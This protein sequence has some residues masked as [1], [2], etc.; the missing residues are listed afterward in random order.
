MFDGNPST[1]SRT[2]PTRALAWGRDVWRQ[3][4][5][6]LALSLLGLALTVTLSGYGY[7]VSQY[8]ALRDNSAPRV[9][10]LKLWIEQRFWFASLSKNTTFPRLKVRA[11]AQ[12]GASAIPAA[13]PEFS[14]LG[15][16]AL[17]CLTARPRVI[18][19]FHAAIPLRSPPLKVSL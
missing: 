1:Q 6:P 12:P 8:W 2:F 11:Y 18:P 19:Y 17:L 10:V 4:A 16:T 15:V 3:I 5:N 14:L 9:P 7:R 13:A